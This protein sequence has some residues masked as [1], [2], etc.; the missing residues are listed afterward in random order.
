MGET[1]GTCAPVLRTF[2]Y[3]ENIMSATLRANAA[4]RL[5]ANAAFNKKHGKKTRP[6]AA[7][8]R[9]AAARLNARVADWQRSVDDPANRNKDMS[10]YHKPGSMKVY[11]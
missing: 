1:G 5:S 6:A 10:G 9:K 3:L 11:A 4:D 7:H 8:N 2:N